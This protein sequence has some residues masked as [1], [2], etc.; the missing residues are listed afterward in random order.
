MQPRVPINITKMDATITEGMDF[1]W[2]GCTVNSGPLQIHL[3]DKARGEGDNRGE[4]DYQKKV[5]RARFNVVIDLIGITRLLARTAHCEP[6]P[7]IR[8]VLHSE[9]VITEDHNFGLSGPME[10][11]PHPLFGAEGVSAVVLPGR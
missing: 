5:A 11:L 8:A 9:G 1:L 10:V 3:D 7:P 4:L 6:M 2:N